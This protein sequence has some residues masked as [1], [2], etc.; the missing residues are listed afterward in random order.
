MINTGERKVDLFQ[1]P[2]TFH[3]DSQTK[4][5]T[6]SDSMKYAA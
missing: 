4:E 2:V 1:T 6:D 3:P 5:Q